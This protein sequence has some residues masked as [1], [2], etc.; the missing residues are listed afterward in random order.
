MTAVAEEYAAAH[1]DEAQLDP[2]EE[3]SEDPSTHATTEMALLDAAGPYINIEQ[4][5]DIDVA[6][7]RDHHVTRRAVLDL[8]DG[9][10]VRVGDL[11]GE[12]SSLEVI[13]QG[14]G[15]LSLAIDSIRRT[16]DERARRAA[17]ALT[18][19]AFDSLSFALVDEDG[20]PAVAFSVPG[21]GVR[22]G[23]YALP[24][25]PIPIAA[26]PWWAPIRSGLPDETPGTGRALLWHG[27]GYDITSR[28]DS[29]GE[30]A[31]IAIEVAPNEWPVAR[32]PTPVRRI[33]R[34]DRPPALPA[35]LAAL[36]RAFDEAAFYSGE[37]RTAS[38]RAPSPSTVV[39]NRPAPLDARAPTGVLACRAADPAVRHAARAACRARVAPGDRN[40]EE[41][42]DR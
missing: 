13:R 10:L 37:V 31:N 1:A 41:I 35:T 7:V 26:G 33:H 40:D 18:G 42:L 24:L 3:A 9:H 15:L 32:V 17:T 25:P 36:R 19:F 6:G 27:E 14:K 12:A 23:G 39:A 34:L 29:A 5:V 4:H 30:G 38:N 2:E 16:H 8:R 22:A 11:V 28:E 21:R 20:A